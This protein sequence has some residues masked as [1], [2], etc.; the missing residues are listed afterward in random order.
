MPSLTP[1]PLI[2]NEVTL[3]IYLFE[4]KSCKRC[5]C[6]RFYACQEDEEHCGHTTMNVTTN[7]QSINKK[8]NEFIS[9]LTT[10]NCSYTRL[11]TWERQP[12]FKQKIN[13]KL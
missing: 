9:E 12:Q 11:C 5:T 8:V 13:K 3:L 6:G 1:N 4:H 10:F 2:L 7:Y